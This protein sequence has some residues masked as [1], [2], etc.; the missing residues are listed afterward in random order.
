MAE[1]NKVGIWFLP[2]EREIIIPLTEETD[3]P[4]LYK[5]R[6]NN[7]AQGV[8]D[9]VFA[10]METIKVYTDD[11]SVKRYYRAYDCRDARAIRMEQ[12]AIAKGKIPAMRI[13]KDLG[14]ILNQFYV[15]W[16][17]EMTDK[18]EVA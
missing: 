6:I 18:K 11:S 8:A 14:K 4:D 5:G 15:S 2:D 7:P 1:R 13:P 9:Y 3:F 16:Q 10:K 12:D 17:L